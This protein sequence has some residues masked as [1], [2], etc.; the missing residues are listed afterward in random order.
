MSNK[1]IYYTVENEVNKVT[2]SKN[3]DLKLIKDISLLK[4]AQKILFIYDKNISKNFIGQNL[5][6]STNRNLTAK[7]TNVKQTAVLTPS[8]R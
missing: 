4:S 8:S 1:S 5:E 6:Y 7:K 3:I 2:Y